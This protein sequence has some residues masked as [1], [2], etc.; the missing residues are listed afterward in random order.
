VPEGHYVFLFSVQNGAEADYAPQEWAGDSVTNQPDLFKVLEAE[1][2][3]LVRQLEQTGA[4]PYAILYQKGKGVIEESLSSDLAGEAN[5]S[6]QMPRYFTEGSMGSQVVGPALRWEAAHINVAFEGLGVPD[7]A[8]RFSLI[9]LDKK[10][11]PL[12]TLFSDTLSSVSF[13]LSSISV[14]QYPY[15]QLNYFAQDEAERSMADLANWTVLFDPA[16]DYSITESRESA[17][18]DSIPQGATASFRF[19]ILSVAAGGDSLRLECVI[20]HEA[21]GES[22][23]SD[24]TVWM[25]TDSRSIDFDFSTGDLPVGSYL[26]LARLNPDSTVKERYYFNNTLGRKFF[27]EADREPP[28]LDVAFDGRRIIDGD[29]V[30]KNASIHIQLQDE[31][32]N[33][34]LSDTSILEVAFVW[35]DGSERQLH[36][37]DPMVQFIPGT[38]ED[39][40]AVLVYEADF[41]QSGTY[42]LTV[43]ARDASNNLSGGTDYQRRFKV[44]TENSIS[45]VLNY[46]NP[47]STSTQFVYTLTG[48]PP[49][50]FR[51]QIATVSGRIVKE[52][53]QSEI[54][55]LQV[56]THRTEYSW[57]GTDEYGDRLANGVYLYRIIAKDDQGKDYRSYAELDNASSQGGLESFFKNGWGKMVIM[58]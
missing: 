19:D 58:R 16:G 14:E 25:D 12:D 3:Q 50:E 17:A 24:A 31:N 32:P 39:N 45:N 53:T 4:V 18:T 2:A 26:L 20:Q 47:F 36:F 7:E 42:Q 15:L 55:P 29:L 44:F 22:R 43:R 46:P 37:D 49:A 40:R 30:R 1:G 33:L 28:L 41:E 38:P 23:S 57:D 54:G 48:E 35:P 9:G 34:L 6:F 5:V 13:D 11:T 27:V 52:I 8:T 21:T 10:R 51:I 56:G